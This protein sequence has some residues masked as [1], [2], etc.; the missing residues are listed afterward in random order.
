MPDKQRSAVRYD[1]NDYITLRSYKMLERHENRLFLLAHLLGAVSSEL[2]L[3]TFECET[4]A[5]L[6]HEAAESISTFTCDAAVGPDEWERCRN[7][8]EQRQA[9]AGNAE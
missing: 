4:L 1:E 6:L 8:F 2:E 3:G 7:A 9:E 5:E